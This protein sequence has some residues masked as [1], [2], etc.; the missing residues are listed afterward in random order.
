MNAPKIVKC[1]GKNVSKEVKDLYAENYNTLGKELKTDKRH[2][3]FMD[4]KYC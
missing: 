2:S 1:L 3:M 4:W